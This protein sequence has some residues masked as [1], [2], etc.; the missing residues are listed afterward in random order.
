MA[1]VRVR[2][3]LRRRPTDRRLP[4]WAA[5][6]H[7]AVQPGL[8]QVAVTHEYE[9][10]TN[11]KLIVENYHECFHC[12][13]I[14]PELCQ[15]SSTGLRNARCRQRAVA[16]RHDVAARRRRDH[17]TGR[18]VR[19]G[20]PSRAARRTGARHRLHPRL[21]QPADQPA[22]R[23]RDDPSHGRPGGRPH[24][25]GVPVA[26]PRAGA[27]SA[28]ASTRPTRRTSGTS[29]TGRTGRPARASSAVSRL[30]AS[31]PVRCR[32]PPSTS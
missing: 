18:A 9:L 25:G 29:P 23:L 12:D 31:V 13:Q 7:R 11:W 2:E 24:C 10:A 15:V 32:R 4:R 6:R 16:R 20:D 30:A 14:H 28:R 27:G 17:V 3:H 5:R 22:P 1:R 26:V 8:A 19:W 21:P